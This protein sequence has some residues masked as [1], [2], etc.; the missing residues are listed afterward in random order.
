MRDLAASQLPQPRLPS[1]PPPPL[2]ARR[3]SSVA[4]VRQTSSVPRK[5]GSWAPISKAEPR[6]ASPR[7][8][9]VISN[10]VLFR[11][12]RCVCVCSFGGWRGHSVFRTA[13]PRVRCTGDSRSGRGWS[14]RSFPHQ[15]A[16]H[17]RQGSEA[18]SRM[19]SEDASPGPC[20]ALRRFRAGLFIPECAARRRN[21]RVRA[22]PA[23]VTGGG[24][25]R[26]RAT[27]VCSPAVPG[28]GGLNSASLGCRQRGSGAVFSQEREG[29][30][31]FLAF[32]AP[33]GPRA[34]H[35]ATPLRGPPNPPSSRVRDGAGPARVT[36]T[37]PHIP[38]SPT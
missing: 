20:S 37:D 11:S 19:I 17:H 7:A 24:K 23:A 4:F 26:R 18:P 28:A 29:K 2:P 3:P 30:A 31:A 15:G 8:L 27:H 1:P 10:S 34:P 16:G 35:L 22:S 13:R 36:R 14:S 25:R 5:E 38:T 9:L 21:L 12:E 6:A 32:L 33:A